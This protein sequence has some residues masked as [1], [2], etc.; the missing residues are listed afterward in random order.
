MFAT[1][2]SG[3]INN[4]EC[5]TQLLIHWPDLLSRLTSLLALHSNLPWQIV[6]L[7]LFAWVGG[8]YGTE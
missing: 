1:P 5:V 2:E 7:I 3:A 8:I 6:H 4:I